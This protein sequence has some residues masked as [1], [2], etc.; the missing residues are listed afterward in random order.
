MVA[1]DASSQPHIPDLVNG[2]QPNTITGAESQPPVVK[3]HKQGYKRASDFL[4]NTSNWKVG[5]IL[6]Y[7]W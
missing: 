1:V 5:A 7:H 2:V 6:D 3:S 4:S